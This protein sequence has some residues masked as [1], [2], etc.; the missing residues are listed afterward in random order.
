MEFG[1]RASFTMVRLG[2]IICG[3]SYFD[4][5]K[6]HKK[7]IFTDNEYFLADSYPGVAP[8]LIYFLRSRISPMP[9]NEALKKSLETAQYLYT[10]ER[11]NH[12][13]YTFGLAAYD[14]MIDGLHRDDVGFAA[15]TQYGATGNGIIL[16]THL[17]DNRRAAITFW[18]EKSQ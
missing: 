6:P 18:E 14:A 9:L 1:M 8:E 2:C 11:R 13:D 12:N 17:I 5:L 4:N 15:L 16:L 7:D 10:T 3:R